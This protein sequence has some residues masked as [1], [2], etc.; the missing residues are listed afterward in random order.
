M[1]VELFKNRKTEEEKRFIYSQQC[2]KQLFLQEVQ[3]GA[4]SETRIEERLIAY[5][6]TSISCYLKGI[7]AG[8]SHANKAVSHFVSLWFHSFNEYSRD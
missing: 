1:N 8:E 7:I 5:K 4:N 2:A 3:N 6:E